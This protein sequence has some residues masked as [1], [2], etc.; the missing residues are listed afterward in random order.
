MINK[1]GQSE[2]LFLA[3]GYLLSLNN[4]ICLFEVDFYIEPKV[5]KI[6]INSNCLLKIDN[7]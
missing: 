4:N 2:A 6:L 5:K 7:F 3:C 1:V